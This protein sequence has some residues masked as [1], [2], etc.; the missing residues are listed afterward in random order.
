MDYFIKI[1]TVITRYQSKKSKIGR[2]LWRE[3]P[4]W[5]KYK[6]MCVYYRVSNMDGMNSK[7]LMAL[8]LVSEI[9]KYSHLSTINMWRWK[10]TWQHKRRYFRIFTPIQIRHPVFVNKTLYLHFYFRHLFPT[11]WYLSYYI[12]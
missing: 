6:H 10:N 1:I 9:S 8:F 7:Q 12:V 4:I 3:L 11:T 5:G 2:K